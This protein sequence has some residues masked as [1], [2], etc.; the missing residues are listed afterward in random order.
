MVADE[1]LQGTL[2]HRPMLGRL[3]RIEV[4]GFSN[5][6]C[7]S[8]PHCHQR[9]MRIGSGCAELALVAAASS[10]SFED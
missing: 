5:A 3:R 4:L 7:R 1:A 10:M 9:R 2:R 6:D 8:Q